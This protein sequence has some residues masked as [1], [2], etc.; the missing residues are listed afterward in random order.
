MAYGLTDVIQNQK[1]EI[2]V[3]S[4]L[5]VDENAAQNIEDFALEKRTVASKIS[6]EE[7]DGLKS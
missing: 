5:V 7:K 1:D 3:S 4:T 6:T 2:I